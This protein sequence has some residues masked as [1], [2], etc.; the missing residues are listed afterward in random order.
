MDD[1]PA[2][3]S[4]YRPYV[5]DTAVSFETQTP[6]ID[7]FAERVASA[8]EGWGWYVAERTG[9]VVGYAY[10]SRHRPRDAYARSVEVSAYVHE[11]AH[12]QGLAG[13][14]YHALFEKLEE[15]GYESAYAGITLPNDASVGFHGAFGF[16]SI[17]VFPRVGFKFGQWYDVAWMYRPI[18]GQ[19]GFG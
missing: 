3:L 4:I 11:S 14:L 2:L 10:G 19:R 15:R 7:E 1:A 5:E 13:R 16:R 17:G 9:R 6:T 18:A 8:L 12:R